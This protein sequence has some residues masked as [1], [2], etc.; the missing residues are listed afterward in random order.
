MTTAMFS[1][2]FTYVQ[3]YIHLFTHFNRLIG[4][5]LFTSASAVKKWW[6]DDRSLREGLRLDT[7]AV[8]AEMS[9]NNRGRGLGLC[10]VT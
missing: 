8:C 10:D 4:N 7:S 1:L 2:T 5:I 3:S 9:I 6:T